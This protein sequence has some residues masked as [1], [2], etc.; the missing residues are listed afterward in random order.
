MP[1]TTT[2]PTQHLL[3]LAFSFPVSCSLHISLMAVL[4]WWLASSG[5]QGPLWQS[6]RICSGGL[7][8]FG[9]ALAHG[10]MRRPA[11]TMATPTHPKPLWQN[12]R[13][14]LGG[15]QHPRPHHHHSNQSLVQDLWGTGQT[16]SKAHCLST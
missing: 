11:S 6:L 1:P 3:F 12:L 2:T 10:C 8:F 9:D 13:T 4:P 5:K 7:R 14:C 15:P 16:S